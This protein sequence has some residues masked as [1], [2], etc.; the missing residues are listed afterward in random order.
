VTQGYWNDPAANLAAFTDDGW[1][2]TGDLA[3]RDAEGFLTIVG[4]RTAMINSGGENIYPAEVERALA[5]LPGVREVAVVGVP[6]PEWGETVAVV[7]ECP[8]G[9]TPSLEDVRAY[10]ARTIARYKLPTRSVRVPELPRTATG[11][12]NLWAVRSQAMLGP[13]GAAVDQTPASQRSGPK[14]S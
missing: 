4:R 9:A 11:K 10:A 8:D 13:S 12:L 5:G 7:L 14:I 2:R 6:H 3:E 1:L